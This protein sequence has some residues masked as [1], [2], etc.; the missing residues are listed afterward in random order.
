MSS[1]IRD[2]APDS[3]E[4]ARDYR[5]GWNASERCSEGALERADARDV[6]HAWYD[7]YMDSATGRVKWT[8]REAR[9][10]GFDDAEAYLAHVSDVANASN[11][12]ELLSALATVPV[13]ERATALAGRSVAM[14][15]A[16]AD[17]CGVGDADTL[18]KRQAIAAIVENF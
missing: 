3:P 5:L 15:R 11:A 4:Y 1:T 13:V 7:G 9:R 14:L 6:S 18:S 16:A 12:D 2:L 8:Y 10:A 17:L